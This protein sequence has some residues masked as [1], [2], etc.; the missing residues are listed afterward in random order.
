M[1]LRGTFE[2]GACVEDSKAEPTL[3]R[4]DEPEHVIEDKVDISFG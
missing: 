1:L 3:G 4:V 2:L